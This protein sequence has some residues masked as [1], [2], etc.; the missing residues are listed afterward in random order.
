MGMSEPVD[1]ATRTSLWEL[2]RVFLRLGTVSFGGPAAHVALMEEEIVRQIT[3][4]HLEAES[5]IAIN[6]RHRECLRRAG[7]ALGRVGAGLSHQVSPEY[8]AVDL[9]DALHAVG[10]IIGTVDVEQVLD[11]VFGQFC[12]G[13]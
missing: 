9:K 6:A 4:G 10:Q 2:A 5:A 1:R 11:S 7:E 8:L 3:G 12:I 13:K